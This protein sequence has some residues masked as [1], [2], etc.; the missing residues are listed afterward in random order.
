[1]EVYT[2]KGFFN[3]NGKSFFI[4]RVPK[5]VILKWLIHLADSAESAIF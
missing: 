1:M 5:V 4:L 2:E 3:S